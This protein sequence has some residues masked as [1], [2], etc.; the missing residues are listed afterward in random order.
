MSSL[1]L[2]Q[3]ARNVTSN[4]GEDGIVEAIFSRIGTTSKTCCEFGALDGVSD[5][6]TWNL[7]HN[8]GWRGILIE[9]DPARAKRLFANASQIGNVVALHKAVRTE[10]ED[11]LDAIL[12]AQNTPL[13]F[14]LLVVDIDNDDYFVWHAITKYRPRIVMIEANPNFRVHDDHVATKGRPPRGNFTGSSLKAM[15]RLGQ[16]KGYELALHVGGNAIFA[17]RELAPALNVDDRWWELYDPPKPVSLNR[18]LHWMVRNCA[19]AVL[20]Q[21][22]T[23]VGAR[24]KGLRG[25]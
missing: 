24:V 25:S 16:A 4:N 5:S 19:R 15:C 6:N 11:S 10:G 8:H 18:R 3:H 22:Y 13:D 12:T 9:A 1:W 2:R 21:H 17:L 20:G 14:D 23:A 7:I